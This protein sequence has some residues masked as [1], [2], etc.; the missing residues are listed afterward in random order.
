MVTDLEKLCNPVFQCL[1]NYWQLSCVTNMVDREQFQ[2][3]IVGLMMEARKKARKDPR[4]EREFIWL[5]KPLVFFIDYMV[6][7]GR[8]AF[9]DDWRELS[10]NYNELSGDEKFFDLLNETLNNP[11]FDNSFVLFYIMLGLG[12]DGVYQYNRKYVEQCMLL[13]MEKATTDFDIGSEP[14][15]PPVIKKPFFKRQRKLTVRVVLI[16]SAVFMLVCFIINIVS[17][18]NATENYRGLLKQTSSDA[19]PQVHI[20]IQGGNR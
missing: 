3:D 13:C 18:A 12:F 10:R 15:L 19:S 9:R 17:F 2:S 5:E 7:E 14:V 11:D 4:L 1:C 6:K 8:F 16:A 20:P